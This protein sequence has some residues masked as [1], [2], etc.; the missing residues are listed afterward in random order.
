M[1][2][3]L[4]LAQ[5]AWRR[6]RDLE[7]RLATGYDADH[8]DSNGTIMHMLIGECTTAMTERRTCDPTDQLACPG[9]D[10]SCEW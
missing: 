5:R 1:R 2:R 10:L 7:C 3:Y 9:D 4:D 6:F 8:P